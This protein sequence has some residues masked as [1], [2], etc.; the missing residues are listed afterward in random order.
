MPNL[1]P[2]PTL[3]LTLST[4]RSRSR[5]GSRSRS[6]SR[7]LTPSLTLTLT[8]STLACGSPRCEA[9]YCHRYCPLRR[10][11]SSSP[12]SRH[13]PCRA[14]CRAASRVRLARRWRARGRPGRAARRRRR[15]RRRGR[16]SSLAP[17]LPLAPGRRAIRRSWQRCSLR[18][19]GRLRV[20]SRLEG[21]YGSLRHSFHGRT[22]CPSNSVHCFHTF[23]PQQKTMYHT[24]YEVALLELETR[25]RRTG[26]ETSD[27]NSRERLGRALD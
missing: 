10:P 24:F 20:L 23:M 15:A 7:S 2:N 11:T 18:C 9:S 1:S 8:R 6:R 12:T 21:R 14:Q 27:C 13:D 22:P 4:S 16:E 26:R 17:T 19:G 5:S 3:T 25:A